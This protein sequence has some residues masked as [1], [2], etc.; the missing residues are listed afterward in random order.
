MDGDPEAER[1]R[2]T[3][4]VHGSSR[5]AVIQDAENDRAWIQSTATVPA[6]R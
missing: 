3:E 6:E 2:Y 1:Y 4:Y 5:V